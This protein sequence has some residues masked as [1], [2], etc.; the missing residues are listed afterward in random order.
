MWGTF[1]SS[2]SALLLI[3]HQVGTMKLIKN[4][5]LEVAKRNTLALAKAA[6]ILRIPVVLT[7]GTADKFQGPLLPELEDILPEAFAARVK[8][9][10]VVNT[11]EDPH[12]RAAVEKT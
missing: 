9:G 2:N 5:P 12:F 11:W 10:G 8:R 4:I 7:T 3:D 1:T 6:K